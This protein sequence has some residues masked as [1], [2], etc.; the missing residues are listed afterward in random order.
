[1]P[2]HSTTNV[3]QSSGNLFSQGLGGQ[4]FGMKVSAM[5]VPSG[6][7]KEIHVMPHAQ[8][9]VAAGTSG[10]TLACGAP[11]GSLPSTSHGLPLCVSVFFSVS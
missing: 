2:Q 1:M 8:L 10:C 9:L 5:L 3:V 11:T 4:K 7:S 6:G